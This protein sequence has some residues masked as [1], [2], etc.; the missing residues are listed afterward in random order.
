MHEL[1]LISKAGRERYYAFKPLQKVL[2]KLSEAD[3][4]DL[5]EAIGKNGLTESIKVVK[6]DRNRYVIL[7]GVHRFKA[8]EE[9]G[10][11]NTARSKVKVEFV[12]AKKEDWF[13]IGL[14]MN[15][16]AKRGRQ[17]KKRDLVKALY[18]KYKERVKEPR[19]EEFRKELES[20]GLHLALETVKSYVHSAFKPEH[21][22]QRSKQLQAPG[23]L[24]PKPRSETR[25]S[26][27]PQ[28]PAV[29]QE[30]HDI[31]TDPSPD[32]DVESESAQISTDARLSNSTILLNMNSVANQLDTSVEELIK[33]L[34]ELAPDLQKA[35][36]RFNE[37]PLDMLRKCVEALKKI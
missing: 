12:E 5:K 29:E 10:W 26:A 25:D 1:K 4:E 16:N 33:C 21:H 35:A 34:F 19:V 36:K 7:D 6:L 20:Y 17:I 11:L 8:V 13:R 14:M 27:G 23:G 31:S 18:K 2:P 24:H 32:A 15:L 9:L 22:G 3:Y 37:T 30:T 28:G